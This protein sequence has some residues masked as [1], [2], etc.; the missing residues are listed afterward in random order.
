MMAARCGR[1]RPPDV[2]REAQIG[3]I[4]RRC[5]IVGVTCGQRLPARLRC[6]PRSSGRAGDV[7]RRGPQRSRPAHSSITRCAFVPLNPNELMPASASALTLWPR[8][9][10]SRHRHGQFG[11]RNMRVRLFLKCRCGGIVSCCSAR[12]TFRS[13]AMPAAR[14]EVADVGLDRSDENRADPTAV[15]VEH[16]PER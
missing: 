14:F 8:R 2:G 15:P 3:D 12:M 9:R 7:R 6:E 10:V 16:V 13:P 11:P 5:Q 1:D 4:T